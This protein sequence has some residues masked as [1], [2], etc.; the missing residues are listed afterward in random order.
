MNALSN[1]YIIHLII[2]LLVSNTL[3]AQFVT[4]KMIDSSCIVGDKFDIYISTP[5]GFH[6]DSTYS[7]VYYLDANITSGRK[8]L[9]LLSTSE[10]NEKLQKIIFIGI[11]HRGNFRAGRSRDFL[12]PSKNW[13][14]EKLLNKKRGQ[15]ER[16]YSYLKNEL[17][18]SV[19]SN[20]HIDSGNNSIIGHSLGG[21]FV[22]FSLLKQEDLFTNYFALSPSLWVRRYSIYRFNHIDSG[23]TKQKNLYFT[24][25]SREVLNKILHGTNHFNKFLSKKNYKGLN[26]EYEIW[27]RKTH[28]TSENPALFRIL[29]EKL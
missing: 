4:R 10:F 8:L 28:N 27:K 22:V 11:G 19:S 1:L 26:Y 25:G 24:S 23:F 7:I 14:K 29:K 9:L 21:L 13:T 16:F 3:S 6:P 20:F 18:P 12:L 15:I 17:M 2:L 5:Q